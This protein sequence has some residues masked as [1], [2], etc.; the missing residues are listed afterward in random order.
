MNKKF[1]PTNYNGCDYLSMLGLKLIHVSKRGRR[2]Q[3][4]NDVIMTTMA[5]LFA[6][7][8]I[9]GVWTVGSVV[10]NILLCLQDMLLCSWWRHRMEIFSALLALCEGNPPVTGGF[11]LTKA[12]DAEL[13]CFLWSAWTK[14]WAN[15]RD[16]GD[17]RRLRPS[18]MTSL[19]CIRKRC[20][21]LPWGL[22]GKWKY[23]QCI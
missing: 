7:P 18:P 13:W 22:I 14:G 23:I 5:I 4:Y 10:C 15:N 8:F 21:M 19:E 3:H 20:W 6:Q 16:A 17:L 1:Y 11:S 2:E 9:N 12:N